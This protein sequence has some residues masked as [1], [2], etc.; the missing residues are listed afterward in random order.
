MS[1]IDEKKKEYLDSAKEEEIYKKLE[2]EE[3]CEIDMGIEGLDED[4]E[5][6]NKKIEDDCDEDDYDDDFSEIELNEETFEGYAQDLAEIEAKEIR[7]AKNI[8]TQLWNM[9]EE[10]EIDMNKFLILF[11]AYQYFMEE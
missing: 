7:I 11:E 10:E 1:E 9:S 3:D 4:T 8:L 5:T 2:D 6:I